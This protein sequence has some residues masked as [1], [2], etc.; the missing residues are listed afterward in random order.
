MDSACSVA[1]VFVAGEE[2]GGEKEMLTRSSLST[3][4]PGD[5]GKV[6]Q[7][8]HGA[9]ALLTLGHH[10]VALCLVGSTLMLN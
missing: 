4:A 6:R 2:K 1:R 5:S 10:L 8:H 9:I 3:H 7:W